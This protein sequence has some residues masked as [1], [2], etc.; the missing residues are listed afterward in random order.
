MKRLRLTILITGGFLVLSLLSSDRTF[1]NGVLRDGYG[2]GSMAMGGTSVAFSRDPLS[3]MAGNPATLTLLDRPMLSLSLTG[4]H[5]N[6][7][8]DN[9]FNNHTGLRRDAGAFPEFALSYPL[10]NSRFTFGFALKVDS[11]RLADWHY[12]D[13]PGG[14]DGNTSYGLQTHR[15]EFTALSATVGTGLEISDKLSLGLGA[16]LVYHRVGLDVPFIFQT[17]PALAGWKTLLDLET[18]GYGWYA[19]LGML[20]RHSENLSFGIGYIS[21]ADLHSRGRARGD[22]SSQLH[23]LGLDTVPS[24]FRYDAEVDTALPQMVSAGLSWQWHDRL[25]LALQVDWI[26]W[27][28]AFDELDVSLDQ[29]SNDA[30]NGLTGGDA[31]RDMVPVAWKDRIVYRAGLEIGLSEDLSLQCGYSYGRSP[32]PSAL[33]TPLN[34]SIFEH[35]LTAGVRM[36]RGPWQL[37]LAYQYHLPNMESVGTSRYRSG[38]YS[39]SSLEVSAHLLALSVSYAF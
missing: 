19:S 5:G 15:A 12:V 8:F 36:E 31:L 9:A 35:T 22:V 20:Y 23:S 4:I 18:D 17:Q 32:I 11:A 33:I 3:S 7:D 39:D 25:R 13:A 37:G 29:G 16:G 2:T 14:V 21:K 24:R 1:A 26:G 38:E 10:P 28:D 30:I 34:G 6:G 27:S